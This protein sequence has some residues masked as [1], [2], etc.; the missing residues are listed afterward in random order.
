MWA[1]LFQI[2]GQRQAGERHW[3][4]QWG[5]FVRKLLIPEFLWRPTNTKSVKW[6]I[7]NVF[8]VFTQEDRYTRQLKDNVYYSFFLSGENDTEAGRLRLLEIHDHP[9]SPGAL[10]LLTASQCSCFSQHLYETFFIYFYPHTFILNWQDTSIL[11]VTPAWKLKVKVAQ[12]CLTLC[13]P[14]DYTVHGFL[15]TRIL[16]WVTFPLSRGSS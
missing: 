9:T 2:S 15:Q 3:F 10:A 13:N 14:M 11:H 7:T 16:E 4:L 8:I 5:K 1:N 6:M 12:S